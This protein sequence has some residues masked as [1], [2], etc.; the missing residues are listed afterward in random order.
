MEKQNWSDG[1]MDS[2]YSVPMLHHF[3]LSL[4][5]YSISPTLHW[6]TNPFLSI[7]QSLASR[8]QPLGEEISRA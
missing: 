1:L 5:H 2:Q 8:T 7:L 4:L 6:S 3:N